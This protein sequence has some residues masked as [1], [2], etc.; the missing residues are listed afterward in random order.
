MFILT[1]V[2]MLRWSDSSRSIVVR[3]E[4]LNLK[5][6]QPIVQR[7]LAKKRSDTQRKNMDQQSLK[8][9]STKRSEFFFDMHSKGSTHGGTCEDQS[10]CLR[11]KL[12]GDGLRQKY[13]AYR[14]RFIVNSEDDCQENNI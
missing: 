11:R 2:A 14:F 10:L 8:R 4:I 13:K 12:Q 5:T 9:R 7:I 1:D 3:K 6:R